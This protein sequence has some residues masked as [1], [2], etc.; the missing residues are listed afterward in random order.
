MEIKQ[1]EV[2]MLLIFAE[3][4]QKHKLQWALSGGS[5]LGAIR[6]EGFIPW[7]DDI[8]LCLSR[9]DYNYLIKNFKNEQ[10]KIISYEEGTFLFPFARIIDEKTEI[11]AQYSKVNSHLWLDIFPVDGL[12]NDRNQVEQV[13]SRCNFYRRILMLTDARLGTGRTLFHKYSK[14]ILKPISCL[15]GAK[16]CAEKIENIAQKIP[17][18]SAQYV[19]AITWGLYGVGECM[20]KS[21][22][23]KKVMVNFEKYQ[24]PTFSCWD[25]Y[26]KGLYGDYMQLPPVEKRISHDMT[27]Y[28]VE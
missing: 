27:V 26:L 18:E 28:L 23:E 13:Y 25:S 12:P 11:K 14:Y 2:Q 15:Y 4:C 7:D 5:L 17:Y 8:D 21:D 9:P 16:R 24:F 20:I 22:F 6:H 3:F 10:L 19:G 1:R